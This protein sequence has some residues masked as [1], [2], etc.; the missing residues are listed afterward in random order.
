MSFLES[1]AYIFGHIDKSTVHFRVQEIFANFWKVE[2][3]T[4][5]AQ[6]FRGAICN[7]LS[8]EAQCDHDN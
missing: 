1:D 3:L 5:S 6:S 7:H 2:L 4:A 8:I